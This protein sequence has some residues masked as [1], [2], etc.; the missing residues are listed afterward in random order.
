MSI[1]PVQIGGTWVGEGH[2]AFLIAE[3]G[4]NHNG[5]VDIAK[6]LIDLAVKCR[7]DAVKFQKRT[8]DVVYSPE[9]LARP[10]QSSFGETNG[11]L[12]FGLEFGEA[13]YREIDNYCRE[14]SILWFASAWDTESVDFLER[15]DPPCHKVASACLT[16][17]ELLKT[18]RAK[19]RPVI[20]STG[21]S[22]LGEVDRALAILDGLP[23][24]ILHCTSTYPCA[25]TE[26]NLA[27]IDTLRE[28]YHRPVGYSGHEWSL[29]PSVFSV[30][31]CGA[32]V[33]ERHITLN[34]A[35]WGT[36]QAASLEAHGMELL[37][38][39]T[40][41]WPLVK[42]DGSK[43]VYRSELPIRNKLRRV[44]A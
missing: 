24:V 5:D 14:R 31:G 23:I 19:R 33:V 21:M 3:I 35:M 44:R 7:F 39:Y 11:D 18:I 15:F 22:A 30:V 1:A 20:L 43:R 13:E 40:R 4:I 6:A 25:E 36:D 12:K 42:G 37:S 10:R 27:V 34:R 26:I 16:D 32:C 2:Q 29:M 8:V 9:E 28:R 41:L 17:C 38:K